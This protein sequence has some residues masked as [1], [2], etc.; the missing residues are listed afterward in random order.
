MKEKLFVYH[1]NFL[2]LQEEI[3]SIDKQS[4]ERIHLLNDKIQ[5][6]QD[7]NKYLEE[8]AT[9]AET[10]LNEYLFQSN[11][12][13]DE[14]SKAERAAELAANIA[15]LN[16]KCLY[17]ETQESDFR[18]EI[19]NLR[20]DLLT[21]ENSLQQKSSEM[22]VMEIN[23]KTKLMIAENELKAK[24]DAAVFLEIQKNMDHLDLKYKKLLQELNQICSENS[25]Q[26]KVLTESNQSLKKEKEE[27]Q[28]KLKIA[29]AKI[30]HESLREN[31]DAAAKK[32]AETEVNEIAERQRAN[33]VQNLYELVKEQLEKSEDRFREFETYNKEIMHKNLVLQENL[34][35][36]Q[37][38]VL[39]Y[40]DPST[41]KDIQAK[42]SDALKENETLSVIN[43]KLKTDVKVLNSKLEAC[44][45]WSSSNEYEFLSLKHQIVD[46]QAAS[47]DKTVIARLSRDVVNARLSENK[48]EQKVHN[49][50]QELE[51]FKSRCVETENL[52]QVE[53]EKG[54]ET[55]LQFEKRKEYVYLKQ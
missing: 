13:S 14:K 38:Q 49:V 18:L 32:L 20:N 17:F 35:D 4:K 27:L 47:D 42:Y 40:V 3:K 53:K 10:K 24:V 16:R 26:L 15:V 34:K 28:E 8:S 5:L 45:L 9:I 52:L 21:A 44:T 7:A 12:A 55:H 25:L 37:N 46:L 6:L 33:H 22:H 31:A 11:L 48:M 50:L 36:L 54:A 41:F 43:E 29:I 2:K 30:H 39:N 19:K 51:E 23:L 1:T